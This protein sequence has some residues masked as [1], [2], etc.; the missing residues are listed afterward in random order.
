MKKTVLQSARTL[1]LVAITGLGGT[2][3][4]ASALAA[5]VGVNADAGA[6]LQVS[7]PASVQAGATAGTQMSTAGSANS[8]AQW[9]SDANKGADRAGE[10]KSGQ[11]A[12]N[13]PAAEQ[14][15]AD[16]ATTKGKRAGKR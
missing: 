4:A 5:G 7:T 15:E 14:T 12:G 10:R 11:A 3:Y 16:T 8:N 13:K 2:G 6:G 1:L 9:Q